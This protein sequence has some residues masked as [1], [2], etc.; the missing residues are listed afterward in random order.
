MAESVKTHTATQTLDPAPAPS[1]ARP[2]AIPP[3]LALRDWLGNRGFGAFVRGRSKAAAL[4]SPGALRVG[5][6]DEGERSADAIGSKLTGGPGQVAGNRAPPLDAGLSPAADA[7]VHRAI[8]SGGQ[9]LDADLQASWAGRA[10]AKLEHVRVHEDATAARSAAML[11]ARAY[12]VGNHVVLGQGVTQ[13]TDAPSVLA[14][15]V[16]HII[17]DGGASTAIQRLPE[18]GDPGRVGELS[19]AELPECIIRQP[20]TNV[21]TYTVAGI[22]IFSVTVPDQT[23]SPKFGAVRKGQELIIGVFGDP[24]TEL[25]TYPQAESELATK[26]YV[27][28]IRDL[29]G[30]E[31]GQQP[32]KQQTAPKPRAKSK[33]KPKSET[34]QPKASVQTRVEAAPETTND[35]PPTVAVADVEP[36]PAEQAADAKRAGE[37]IESYT[38]Y[39]VL[40]ETGLGKDLLDRAMK[41]EPALVQGVLSKLDTWNRDDVAFAFAS[42]AKDDDLSRLASTKEG[43]RLLDHLFDELT[44]GEV[45]EEEQAQADRILALKTKALV[46]EADFAEGILKAQKTI[47]L[48][49]RKPGMTVV[50][51]SPIY[52]SRAANGKIWVKLRTNIY[53]T[54][55]NRDPDIRLPPSIWQGIELNEKDVVGVKFYDDEGRIGYFPALYLI[56]LQ[57]EGTRVALHKM[58]E[59]AGL[60]LTFGTLSLGGEA[61]VAINELSTVGKVLHYGGRALTILDHVA[62]VVDISNS[63]IQEHRSWIIELTGDTGRS[64]I[65]DVESINTYAQ[66]YGLARGAQGLVKLARALRGSYGKWRATTRSL[67]TAM[68]E[69]DK[70]NLGKINNATEKLLQ[71]AEGL[72]DA[73]ANH[74]TTKSPDVKVD[75]PPTATKSGSAVSPAPPKPRLVA[76]GKT[77]SKPRG[78]LRLAEPGEQV[79]TK[80]P[81][82]TEPHSAELPQ[83]LEADI[84]VAEPRQIG[85]ASGAPDAEYSVVSPQASAGG[86]GPKPPKLRAV[87]KSGPKPAQ[88]SPSSDKPVAKAGKQKATKSSPAQEEDLAASEGKGLNTPAHLKEQQAFKR[89]R[90]ESNLNTRQREYLDDML[91]ESADRKLTPPAEHIEEWHKALRSTDDAGRWKILRKLDSSLEAKTLHAEST[92]SGSAFPE[93]EDLDFPHKVENAKMVS[94]EGAE[95]V[96]AIAG[97]EFAESKLGLRESNLSNPLEFDRSR[98][99]T[100][101]DDVMLGGSDEMWL[102]EYKGGEAGLSKGQMDAAWVV[103]VLR[104]CRLKGPEG[105]DYANRIVKAWKAGKLRGVALKTKIVGRTPKKTIVIGEWEYSP[106]NAPP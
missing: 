12:S 55:Y 90:T 18:A 16:G 96:G 24:R 36:S 17:A 37:L 33:P 52:A 54:E 31:P 40:D 7:A 49:Y 103:K 65:K 104:R 66:Y 43:R 70:S 3:M 74:P 57:N 99:G 89:L 60:G 105:V 95:R 102:V 9:A 29:R 82:S 93:A 32:A 41:G 98:F 53:G 45:S 5:E 91:A 46:S 76:K 10:G 86:N 4:A 42:A 59:A 88:K 50:S 11:G 79:P 83:E 72:T 1:A 44:A 26:G 13:S 100:G 25:T 94:A 30:K 47:V 97:R 38:K 101:I 68:S 80:P 8:G 85:K 28:V 61:A 56:Q 2:A 62:L 39:Y 21:F 63:L 75:T 51:A 92:S 19:D 73:A 58:G 27:A 81:P 67:E 64:F 71:E 69:T 78:K 35:E 48:P 87:G 15:E 20:L 22:L 14:H 84:A 23:G 34:A 106:R 77:T 6:S